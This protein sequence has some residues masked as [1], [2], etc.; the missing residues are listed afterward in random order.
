MIMFR[1]AIVFTG[2]F[3][4]ISSVFAADPYPKVEFIKDGDVV[5]VREM[6]LAE[7]EAY[8]QIQQLEQ[9]L[10]AIEGPLE[11]FEDQID[12][13][14]DLIEEQVEQLIEAAV[15]RGDFSDLSAIGE[16][17]FSRLNETIEQMQPALNQITEMADRISE[18]AQRFQELI[19]IDYSEGEIDRVRIIND[20][21]DNMYIR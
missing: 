13:Q 11:Q 2:A 16:M 5:E 18:S 8:E 15:D 19:L 17:E 14:T 3:L 12:R 7:V 6:T 21:D 4:L 20:E 9:E 10:E 1:Q